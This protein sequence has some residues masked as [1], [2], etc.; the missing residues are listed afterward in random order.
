MRSLV[1][2]QSLDAWQLLSLDSLQA[3]LYAVSL[4]VSVRTTAVL[5]VLGVRWVRALRT[6]CSLR[7]TPSEYIYA[8]AQRMSYYWICRFRSMPE[9]K[10]SLRLPSTSPV[11][12]PCLF[13]YAF[14]ASLQNNSHFLTVTIVISKRYGEHYPST[15]TKK[16][17]FI[18]EERD[19][20]VG[21]GIR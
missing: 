5:P 18:G 21:A 20:S 2:E 3:A 11:R 17:L 8:V 12:I 7:L 16:H 9:S 14:K 10:C 4:S 6:C 13:M 1:S 19:P 15:T